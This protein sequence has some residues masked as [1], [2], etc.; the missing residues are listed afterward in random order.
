MSSKFPRPLP[1]NFDPSYG[2]STRPQPT[3]PPPPKITQ[4]Q[5]LDTDTQNLK[6]I[7][8][9][10]AR[11]KK[12]CD[13]I[14]DKAK[15][16]TDCEII[17][18]KLPHVVKVVTDTCEMCWGH[19][20]TDIAGNIIRACPA[21]NG[22]GRVGVKCEACRGDGE[23]GLKR[24]NAKCPEPSCRHGY[25][26]ERVLKL[27]GDEVWCVN[28]GQSIKMNIEGMYQTENHGMCFTTTRSAELDLLQDPKHFYHDKF[29][30]E[31]IGG[32]GCK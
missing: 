21:C 6:R 8:E 25:Q 14:S 23:F 27:P 13:E 4:R 22:S 17:L 26:T 24:G 19:T 28:D 5:R 15:E 30:C 16:L 2:Q 18:A 20:E 9:L 7:A 3:P 10:E 11:D 32:A 29:T 31:L 1:E 12:L